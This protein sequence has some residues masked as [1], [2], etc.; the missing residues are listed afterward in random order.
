MSAEDRMSL[1]ENAGSVLLPLARAAIAREIGRALAVAEEH[2]W[3]R[4][5]GACFITL[6]HESRLRGC[7]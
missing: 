5:P 6:T 7:I 1:P 3:L 2:A 4:E